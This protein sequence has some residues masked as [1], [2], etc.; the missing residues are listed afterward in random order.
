MVIVVR[1]FFGGLRSALYA[2]RLGLILRSLIVPQEVHDD[3]VKGGAARDK[4]KEFLR[5]VAMT[6]LWV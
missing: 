5:S 6:R 1:C 3:W 4:I 2:F